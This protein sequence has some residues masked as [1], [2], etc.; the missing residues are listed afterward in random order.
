MY[1]SHRLLSLMVFALLIIIPMITGQVVK[2]VDLDRCK[3]GCKSTPE[4]NQKCKLKGGGRCRRYIS[5][6]HSGLED[7]CCCNIFFNSPMA[8]SLV[9][10]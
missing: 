5:Y 2:Y 6:I 1:S 4:C 3:L 7:Y 9:R 8:P 10:S